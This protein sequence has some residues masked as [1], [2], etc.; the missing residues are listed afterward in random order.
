MTISC[1]APELRGPDAADYTHPYPDGALLGPQRD[2]NA[3]RG[4]AHHQ[5]GWVSIEPP[6]DAAPSVRVY[7]P[8]VRRSPAALF[9]IHGG[10]LIIGRAVQDDRRGRRASARLIL[11]HQRARPYL[12]N[13]IF[14]GIPSE[15]PTSHD[16]L[17]KT[18]YPRTSAG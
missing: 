4:H 3:A 18:L 15:P 14:S 2:T 16:L 1:V 6:R 10:G 12:L 13:Y 7:R 11:N 8:A 17:M 9:W 5:P